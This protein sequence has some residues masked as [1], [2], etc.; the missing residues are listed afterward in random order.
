MS[1]PGNRASPAAAQH[2]HTSFHNNVGLL[3]GAADPHNQADRA[4]HAVDQDLRGWTTTPSAI[5]GFVM[6]M[7]VMSNSVDITVDR[8]A[9]IL[10][11]G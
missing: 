6:A 10:I 1:S 4:R 11:F 8:P 9:V 5:A 7:R 3:P 2:E